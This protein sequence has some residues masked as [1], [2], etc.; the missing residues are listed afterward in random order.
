MSRIENISRSLQI[1]TAAALISSCSRPVEP[2]KT[3]TPIV[4][5]S[6][7]PTSTLEPPTPTRITPY[8]CPNPRLTDGNP[9]REASSDILDRQLAVMP[10]GIAT[11]V[12]TKV[13]ARY[14][15]LIVRDITGITYPKRIRELVIKNP[16]G[17]PT[18]FSG[19][20]VGSTKIAPLVFAT[21]EGILFYVI[22]TP[23][24]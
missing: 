8:G 1:V 4:L 16:D 20:A 15:Y 14:P 12:T 9:F 13:A 24:Q 21:C 11:W 22:L 6:P 18:Y 10:N 5:P 23:T 17:I 7:F 2:A 3:P 19:D